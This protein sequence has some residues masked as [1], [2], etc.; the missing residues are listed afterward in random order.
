MND[1][2]DGFRD[3]P[4]ETI[5]GLAVLRMLDL[6]R[7][8]EWTP[9]GVSPLQGRAPCNVLVFELQGGHQAML[10]PSGTEP[11]LKY[12]FYATAPMRP[13]ADL[14]EAKRKACDVLDRLVEDLTVSSDC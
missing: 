8:R 5:G 12:Y 13:G 7:Q 4:P 2:V 14:T 3:Q 10:R 9:L 6:Q 11:K 1:I